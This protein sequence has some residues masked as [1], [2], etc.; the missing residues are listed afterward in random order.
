MDVSY[1]KSSSD[2]SCQLINSEDYQKLIG[3][4]LYISV[5]SRPD[6][7]AS[8]SIL[9]QKVSNPTQNDWNQ[10]KQALKYLKETSNIKLKLS[11][12]DSKE[13]DLIGYADANWAEDRNS[14]KSNSGYAFFYNG[15]LIN[16]TCRKQSCVSLSSTE[17]EF[18]ALSDACQKQFGFSD[19]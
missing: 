13:S 14:R 18:I 1:Y 4:L 11:R 3:C 17:A 2:S 10:L 5:N 19:Y 16:W 8:V 7:A 12:V 9:A 15:G 6:I